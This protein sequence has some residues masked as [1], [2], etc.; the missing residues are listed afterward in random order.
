M[1]T[2]TDDYRFVLFWHKY[3][4]RRYCNRWYSPRTDAY[5][6]QNQKSPTR[7][8][9]SINIR[10][11]KICKSVNNPESAIDNG[12]KVTVTFLIMATQFF[13]F[14]A[15]LGSFDIWTGWW[16]SRHDWSSRPSKWVQ[17]SVYFPFYSMF[18][19]V[20]CIKLCPFKKIISLFYEYHTKW[21]ISPMSATRLL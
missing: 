8:N 18:V 21:S 14:I 7:K 2:T 4:S 9:Q 20:N 11:Q 17:F 12:N 13:F 3:F 16:L 5:M 19:I 1:W 10:T 6:Q 15:T